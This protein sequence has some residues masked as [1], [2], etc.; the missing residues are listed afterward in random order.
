MRISYY[1]RIAQ[2][3]RLELAMPMPVSLDKAPQNFLD[4]TKWAQLQAFASNDLIALTFLNATFPDPDDPSDFFFPRSGSFE[5]AVGCYHLGR[6]LQNQCRRQLT[7]RKLLATGVRSNGRREII[8]PE[9]WHNIWPMFATNRATGPN[10]LFDDV[11]I[12]KAKPLETR[13]EQL[14]NECVDWL[15]VHDE[16]ARTQKKDALLYLA[17][18]D[19]A[20]NLTHSVFNAAYKICFG[21]GRGRP[22]KQPK[23]F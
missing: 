23:I 7:E 18:S 21:Y 22:R 1:D 10:D 3:C 17:R 19:I 9:Q 12:I 20:A 6:E 8:K 15:R 16:V 2:S 5:E 4:Q 14:L 13:S 11:K